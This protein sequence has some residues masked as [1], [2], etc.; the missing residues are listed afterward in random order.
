M[1]RKSFEAADLRHAVDMGTAAPKINQ[2]QDFRMS[3]FVVCRKATDA[4]CVTICNGLLVR[5]LSIAGDLE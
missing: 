3:R 4:R 1:K 2:P 5:R